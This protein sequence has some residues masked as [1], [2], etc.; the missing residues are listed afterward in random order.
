MSKTMS[1]LLS[2]W[3]YIYYCPNH[4]RHWDLRGYFVK[5]HT[6]LFHCHLDAYLQIWS[7]QISLDKLNLIF[8]EISVKYPILSVRNNLKNATPFLLSF[9]FCMFFI[10]K[11]S[12]MM[13][14]SR[15]RDPVI[16]H[17]LC[18]VNSSSTFSNESLMAFPLQLRQTFLKWSKNILYFWFTFLHTG[19]AEGCYF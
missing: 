9:S 5:S 13:H 1:Y 6:F 16:A 17:M 14:Q 15:S 3:L 2:L 11:S 7:L 12:E 8:S 4:A 18:T 19:S 10:T